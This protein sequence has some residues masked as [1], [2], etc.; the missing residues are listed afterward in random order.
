MKPCSQFVGFIGTWLDKPSKYELHHQEVVSIYR[1]RIFN[2]ELEIELA[3]NER[4][5]YERILHKQLGIAEQNERDA[6]EYQSIM[7]PVSPGRM[8][9][10]LEQAS[11]SKLKSDKK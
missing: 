1:E 6:I 11:L 8:K 9:H 2:L 3:R 5:K 7:R 10:S 4:D